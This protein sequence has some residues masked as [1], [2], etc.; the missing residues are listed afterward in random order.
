MGNAMAVA[1]KPSLTIADEPTSALDVTIQAEIVDLLDELRRSLRS[2]IILITHDL[3]LLTKIA[4]RES[5]V[6]EPKHP[7]TRR[8]M[9]SIKYDR[10]ARLKAIKGSIP[11]LIDPPRGCRFVTRC[12]LADRTCWDVEPKLRNIASSRK[13]ACHKV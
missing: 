9:E 3:A 10:K 12:P 1:E 11:S 6:S 4:D 8:L 7:Y 13:A 2:S 5:I